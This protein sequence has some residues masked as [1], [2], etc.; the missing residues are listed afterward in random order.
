M[1]FSWDLNARVVEVEGGRWLNV[2]EVHGHGSACHAHE[3]TRNG[4]GDE[5]DFQC[6]NARTLCGLF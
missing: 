6:G 4:A 3:C 5:F 2:A 1:T